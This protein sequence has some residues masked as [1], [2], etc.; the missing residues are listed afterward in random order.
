MEICKQEIKDE[1]S[2]STNLA[3][4]CDETTDIFDKS[5]MVIVFRYEKNGEP[6]ERFWGFFQPTSLTAQS[7]A[8]ILLEEL[9]GLVGHDSDKL[10]AQTYDGAAALSGIRNGVQALIKAVYPKAHF[11]HCYAHQLNLILQKATSANSKVRI[12]FNSLSGIPPFFSKSP[13]RMAALEQI[14]GRRIPSSP[15]TRWNF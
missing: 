10:I 3:V 8:S 14:A 11:I 15:S 6:V 2:K 7:L 1:I 13:Q 4:M 12:F 9:Q 5:Q